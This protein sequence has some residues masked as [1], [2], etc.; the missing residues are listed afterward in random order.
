MVFNEISL[1]MIK[2]FISPTLII[3]VIGFIIRSLVNKFL[4]TEVEKALETNYSRGMRN[5]LDYLIFSTYA[6]LVIVAFTAVSNGIENY[7]KYKS[8]STDT[9]VE[10]SNGILTGIKKEDSDT[11]SRDSLDNSSDSE[12]VGNSIFIIV[13]AFLFTCLMAY[14]IYV[15][16]LAPLYTKRTMITIEQKEY[17]V[18]KRIE[19]NNVLLE[20]STYK[21][22]ILSLSELSHYDI[23]V[24]TNKECETRRY[25][26][27][28][29][30]VNQILIAFREV[31][32][33]FLTLSVVMIVVFL[34]IGIINSPVL[35]CITLVLI[36]IYVGSGYR[37]GKELSRSETSDN[38][39]I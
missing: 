14:S 37:N 32:K 11:N 2:E 6:F 9:S 23:R 30:G 21:Y 4:S 34:I 20:S 18:L 16:E 13:A 27:I 19:S 5:I 33:I 31:N 15:K 36:S 22:R 17:I 3:A 8:L 12:D 10:Q 26:S 28:F 29:D 7:S 38:Y 25:R 35:F 1:T 39:V 24:E